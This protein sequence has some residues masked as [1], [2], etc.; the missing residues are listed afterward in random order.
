MF[1]PKIT[2]SI[3]LSLC[4]AGREYTVKICLYAGQITYSDVLPYQGIESIF[5]YSLLGNFS[6]FTWPMTLGTN[7]KVIRHWKSFII[8]LHSP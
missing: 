1:K 7:T 2:E 5:C 8:H 3:K 4:K 6:G